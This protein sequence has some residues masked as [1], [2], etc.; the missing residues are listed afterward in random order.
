MQE[1]F[2]EKIEKLLEEKDERTLKKEL[3]SLPVQEISDVINRSRRGKRKLFILLPAEIQ[4]EAVIFLSRKS[5]KTIIPL[6]GNL[7]IARFLHFMI[8]ESDAADI[9]Q[10]LPEKKQKEIL[11]HLQPAKRSSIEK[12]L[13]YEPDTAGGIMDLNFIILKDIYLLQEARKEIENYEKTFNKLPTVVVEDENKKILGRLPLQKLLFADSKE[14]IKKFAVPIHLVGAHLAK[15]ELI[16]KIESNEKVIGVI[17]PV[18]SSHGV[19]N[20]VFATRL[21]E[22][23]SPRQAAGYSASNGINEKKELIGIITVEELAKISFREAGEDLYGFAGVKKEEEIFDSPLVSVKMRYR[24]LIVNLGTA[25]LAASVVGLFQDTIS[26]LVILAAYMPIVAGMGGNAGT[27]TL[28][29]VVRAL[30]LGEVTLKN[31]WSILRKE[32]VTALGNGLIIGVIAS[33]AAIFWN[34]NPALGLILVAAIML[35]LIVAGIF[36]ALT[37][38]LLKFLKIDPALAASVFITT[39]T[40]VFG[41]LAFLGLAKIFLV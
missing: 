12:L 33:L 3:L 8:Y 15:E 5:K 38:L 6:L 11:E 7:T 41:F 34:A 18:R 39:A 10:F 2:L 24:W 27:Q 32:I 1:N 36:G 35:N 37:P 28:A 26:K 14:K 21:T 20:P 13:K 9:L 40:D 17:N 31:S 30:A 23:S 16:K 19:L 4:A 22:H 25:F 29:V